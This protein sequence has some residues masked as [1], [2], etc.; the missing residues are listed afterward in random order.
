[1]DKNDYINILKNTDLRPKRIKLKEREEHILM[2]QVD[3][4]EELLK[5]IFVETAEVENLKP[6]PIRD[7][8]ILR[9]SIIAEYDATNLYEKFAELVVDENIRKI[10][11]DVAKEEKTHIGEFEA[12]LERL[13]LEHEPEQIA[14]EDE[15]E[16]L[17][18]EKK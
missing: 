2:E 8:Q 12:L 18:G 17:V 9:L 16:D 7:M 10:L 14:G 13:D 11:L 5:E 15:V 4:R 6:G 3:K 1:M